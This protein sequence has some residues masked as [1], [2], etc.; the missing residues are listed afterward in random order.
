MPQTL[1]VT[2][3]IASMRPKESVVIRATTAGITNM[4]ATSVTPM[5]V[6]VA[7]I[8]SERTIMSAASRRPTRTPETSA[9]SGSKVM[10]C[11]WRYRRNTKAAVTSETA[12]RAAI[13]AGSMPRMLPK[14]AFSK[15]GPLVPNFAKSATPSAN[16]A[17]VITPIAAS[18]PSLLRRE[19]EVMAMAEAMPHRPAPRKYRFAAKSC[20]AANPPK[21]E[22]ESPW[23]I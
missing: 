17:V 15:A 13:W 18:A 12:T 2:V 10:N 21:I 23:P 16:E 11:S 3:L 14:R 5:T 6:R 4:A 9:T 8:A 7:R 20:A 19:T 22:C 1:P